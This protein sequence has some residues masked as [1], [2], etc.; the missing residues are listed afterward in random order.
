MLQHCVYQAGGGRRKEAEDLLRRFADG[1]LSSL[2]AEMLG[3]IERV[4]PQPPA[5]CLMEESPPAPAPEPAKVSRD[6]GAARGVPVNSA[7][8]AGIWGCSAARRDGGHSMCPWAAG[9]CWGVLRARACSLLSA[10]ARGSTGTPSPGLCPEPPLLPITQVPARKASSPRDAADSTRV[11]GKPRGG[12]H[13]GSFATHNLSCHAC[14]VVTGAFFL[15]FLAGVEETE[16]KV[17]FAVPE[18]MV[19]ASASVF[20]RYCAC[21]LCGF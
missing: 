21:T 4:V 2:G 7:P 1:A 20:E 18:D 14:R 8:S 10:E 13:A 19:P 11:Q 9:G 6:P 15:L 16:K 17:E 12:G 5:P 3:W